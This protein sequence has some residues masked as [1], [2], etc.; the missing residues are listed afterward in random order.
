[1]WSPQ[2]PFKL[3]V[4]IGSGQAKSPRLLIPLGWQQL[5]KNPYKSD[6]RKIYR[7]QVKDVEKEI[8]FLKTAPVDCPQFC[9]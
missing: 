3:S 2:G 5:A 8:R 6:G 1:M 9:L 4:T 7:E